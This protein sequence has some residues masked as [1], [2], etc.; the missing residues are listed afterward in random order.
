MSNKKNNLS[1]SNGILSDSSYNSYGPIGISGHQGD[2]GTFGDVTVEGFINTSKISKIITLL[3]EG[4]IDKI[5]MIIES[6]IDRELSS[7]LINST[8]LEED[9]LLHLFKV[10]LKSYPGTSSAGTSESIEIFTII[11][12][13][14]LKRSYLT[15][16]EKILN[17]SLLH[18]SHPTIHASIKRNINGVRDK[19]PNSIDF[20]KED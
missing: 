10:Y 12:R 16:C 3:C 2:V 8:T 15:K 13:K 5:K 6:D 4:D 9:Y 11:A 1:K 14:I 7:N 19:I 18:I 20:I 17:E